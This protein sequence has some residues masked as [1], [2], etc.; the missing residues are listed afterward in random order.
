MEFLVRESLTV[1]ILQVDR[2]DCAPWLMEKSPDLLTHACLGQETNRGPNLLGCP[3]TAKL[4]LFG[5]WLFPQFSSNFWSRK[6][7]KTG[8]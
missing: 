8:F 7:K 4:G 1:C 2:S 3:C 6:K 5:F